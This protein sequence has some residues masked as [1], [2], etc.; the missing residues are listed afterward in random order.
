M[1]ARLK[2]DIEKW[3]AVVAKANLTKP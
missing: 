1:P 3:R 2:D